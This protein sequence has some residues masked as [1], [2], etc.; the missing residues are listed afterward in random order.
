MW[1]LFYPNP[2]NAGDS[3]IAAGTYQAF[4][5]ADMKVR[6]IGLEDPV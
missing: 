1:V 6:V 4:L 3:M 5:R 2:G